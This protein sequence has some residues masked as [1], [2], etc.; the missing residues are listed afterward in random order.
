MSH[1][2]TSIVAKNALQHID[3]QNIVIRLDADKVRIAAN[4]SASKDI[5]WHMNFVHIEPTTDGAGALIAGCDGHKLIV[6]HDESGRAETAAAIPIGLGR[7]PAELRGPNMLCV[8]RDGLVF[9]QNAEYETVWASPKPVML[10][11]KAIPFRDVIPPLDDWLKGSGKQVNVVIAKAMMSLDCIDKKCADIRFYHA[12][13]S[14]ALLFAS[15]RANC[16]GMVMPLADSAV[17]AYEPGVLFAPL[18]I[19]TSTKEPAEETG[20]PA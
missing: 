11:L 8:D 6:V 14:E 1:A 15:R 5:R 3:L 17:D 9:I 2:Q 19:R 4:F 16:I 20:E 18:G 10:D 12:P 13:H 7:I